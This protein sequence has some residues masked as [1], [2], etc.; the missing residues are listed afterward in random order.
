MI[1]LKL[2]DQWFAGGGSLIGSLQHHDLI[3]WDDD[4]DVGAHLRHRPQIQ[5]ALRNL[6]PE[7]VTYA[8]DHRDKLS[9]KPLAKKH[10]F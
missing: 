5:E 8:Q 10:H 7:S 6:Q 4:A 3:L 2:Q 1:A 9:L